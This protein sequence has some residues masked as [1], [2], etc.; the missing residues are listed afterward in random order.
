MAYLVVEARKVSSENAAQQPIVQVSEHHQ[1]L[2]LSTTIS[3]VPESNSAA[4]VNVGG[5]VERSLNTST[6][7][8]DLQFQV[9]NQI[10]Q[11]CIFN[12]QEHASLTLPAIRHEHGMLA[13]SHSQRL[14]PPPLL[15]SEVS[16]QS[17][18]SPDPSL[19]QA[20]QGYIYAGTRPPPHFH[21]DQDALSTYQGTKQH[22]NIQSRSHN[23][24]YYGPTT[25][26]LSG[27]PPLISHFLAK[28][29]ILST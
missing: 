13:Q 16:G 19:L 20:A 5:V 11:G 2:N 28:L 14:Q 29:S 25:S 12:G 3:V 27:P 6:S 22:D 23:V 8:E 4:H 1:P 24:P 17:S 9:G 15:N 7:R 21:Q 10:N 18:Y 26:A